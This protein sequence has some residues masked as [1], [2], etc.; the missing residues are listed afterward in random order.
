MEGIESSGGGVNIC[1]IFFMFLTPRRRRAVIRLGV[2][3]QA[4]T[5]PVACLSW[6]GGWA[7][8]RVLLGYGDGGGGGGDSRGG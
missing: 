7:S 4:M 1:S 5:V 2:C 3:V 6:R 8:G